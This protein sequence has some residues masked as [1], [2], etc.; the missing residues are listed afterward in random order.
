MTPFHFVINDAQGKKILSIKRGV[1][2]FRSDVE[3]FD[4][5]EK[6]IGVFKQKF[7]VLQSTKE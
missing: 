7:S 3:V 1:T 5:N 6:R 2:I 4:A